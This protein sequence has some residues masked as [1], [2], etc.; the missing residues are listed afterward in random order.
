MTEGAL[1]TAIVTGGA[2]FLG[3]HLVR[4]LA[5]AGFT[6]R[7]VDVAPRPAELAID[8]DHVQVDVVDRP[9]L[10]RAVAG[11]DV[12]VHAAFASPRASVERI[13]AVNVEGTRNLCAAAAHAGATRVV[14]VS[15]TIVTRRT[16]RHPVRSSAL[17]RLDAY[18]S[19]RRDAEDVALSAVHPG[20]EVSVARPKTFLG[21]GRV[22]AFALV[23]DL[24]RRGRSVPVLGDGQNHY[25]L[26]AV[27]DLVEALVRLAKTGS[28][29]YA[30]GASR[31]GTIAEDLSALLDHAATGA[32]LR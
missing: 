5:A 19:S 7:L 2:G 31:F 25:Q 14:V 28:G 32:R 29:A 12:V 17:G 16:R 24:I 27:G 8:V 10:E 26:L 22:G 18:R 23:F 1:G 30:L 20:F 4:R 13:R 6:V 21:S 9:G 11:A 15:S 3:A